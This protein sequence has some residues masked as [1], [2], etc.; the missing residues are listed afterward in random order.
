MGSLLHA[1]ISLRQLAS[2]CLYSIQAVVFIATPWLVAEALMYLSLGKPLTAVTPVW[3]DELV[4]WHGILTFLKAGFNGGYYTFDEFPAWLTFSHFDPHGP[5]FFVIMS[6]FSLWGQWTP[7]NAVYTNMIVMALGAVSYLYC[8]RPSF[9]QLV[10]ATCSVGTF[11]YAALFLP[12]TMQEC[13]HMAIALCVAGALGGSYLRGEEW[14][15]LGIITVSL[16]L[17]LVS[18]T[19]PMWSCSLLALVLLWSKKHQRKLSSGHW[20]LLTALLPI[21]FILFSKTTAPYSENG[22]AKDILHDVMNHPF[23]VIS[24]IAQRVTLLFRLVGK[25]LPIEIATRQECILLLVGTLFCLCYLAF[26]KKRAIWGV[27]FE[28]AAAIFLSFG[29]PVTVLLA[30]HDIFDLRDYRTFSPHLACAFLFLA[31]IR[32]YHIVGLVT[33][34]HLTLLPSAVDTFKTLHQT[35]YSIDYSRIAHFASEAGKYIRYDSKAPSG[36][37]NTVLT[38]AVTG[39]SFPPE[40]SALPA[41][42][43]FSVL[44]EGDR[45]SF[46]I[47]SKYLLIDDGRAQRFSDK[48]QLQQLNNF[49]QLKLYRNLGVACD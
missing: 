27:S 31:A 17:I 42:I 36:W 1:D 23:G 13:F 48:V 11:W 12:I 8:V 37:C 15:L 24:Y 28:A 7:G 21:I 33:L 18:F 25:G 49:G 32:Q 4:Y 44:L 40:V 3:N 34:F 2:L 46:P 38:Q 47:K 39:Y 9:G 14:R 5:A 26:T 30:M 35:R 22:F 29:L 16:V 10:A 41:G 45:V 43:G 6:F 20:L 19:R